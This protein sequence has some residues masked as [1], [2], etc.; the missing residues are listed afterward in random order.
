MRRGYLAIGTRV[1]VAHEQSALSSTRAGGAGLNT[2]TP[3]VP[4]PPEG[5][6]AQGESKA[7]PLGGGSGATRSLLLA[8][9][10]GE[11]PPFDSAE[12]R[13]VLERRACKP[14]RPTKA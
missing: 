3:F 1:S 2:W 9:E 13:G 11:H 8:S 7:P 4:T 14:N 6:G 12:Q 5:R 10:H